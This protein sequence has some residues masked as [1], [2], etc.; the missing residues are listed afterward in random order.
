[1][2]GKEAS[3]LIAHLVVARTNNSGTLLI[4]DFTSSYILYSETSHNVEYFTTFTYI[5]MHVF[6]I[7]LSIFLVDIYTPV[8]DIKK[9]NVSERLGII[10]NFL[11]ILHKVSRTKD[12]LL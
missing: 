7:Y 8:L 10:F 6:V 3:L 11:N 12:R 9:A 5:R 1:M 4:P 2:A